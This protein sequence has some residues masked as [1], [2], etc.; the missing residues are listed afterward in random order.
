M[1][2]LK[3]STANLVI[4]VAGRGDADRVVPRVQQ[5]STLLDADGF[6]SAAVART[7]GAAHYFLIATIP[8]LLGIVMAAQ[9]AHRR[10]RAAGQAAGEG[11]R[12]HVDPDPSGARV[13]G[14]DHDA[15]VPDPGHR[16]L[17]KGIGLFLMLLAAIGLLVGAVLRMQEQT[18]PT[19]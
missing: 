4:L 1:D 18:K 15:G 5:V 9:V 13:P 2:K 3:L 6:T 12:V 14:D 8:A 16:R 17:D 7:R 11:A 10:V 19:T